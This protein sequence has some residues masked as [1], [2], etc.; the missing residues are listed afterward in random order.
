MS[1]QA[2]TVSGREPRVHVRALINDN[3]PRRYYLLSAFG[4]ALAPCGCNR[5]AL[6]LVI[7]RPRTALLVIAS[8]R[9]RQQLV[10][11]L[12]K[13]TTLPPLFLCFSL[14][15]RTNWMPLTL[16][17][18]TAAPA[19]FVGTRCAASARPHSLLVEGT[20][21]PST[22]AGFALRFEPRGTKMSAS[23]GAL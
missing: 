11:R 22:F 12:Q 7:A 15:E 1:I 10:L 8:Q 23:W 14:G 5:K 18:P 19:G 13:Q 3:R 20:A 17:V 21:S 9:L 4:A 16:F 6:S 2:D